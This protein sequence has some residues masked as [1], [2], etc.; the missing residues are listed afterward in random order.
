[1]ADAR[2]EVPVSTFPGRFSNIDPHD[3]PAGATQVQDNIHSRK[4]G[5]LDVRDGI[6]ATA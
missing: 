2:F 5:Q 4:L 6:Q 1:M 3:V